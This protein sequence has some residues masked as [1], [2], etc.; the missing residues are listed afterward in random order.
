VAVSV[1]WTPMLKVAEQAPPAPQLM[2][3]GLLATVPFPEVVT[4]RVKV[5]NANVAVTFFAASIVTMQLPAPEQA[6]DHPVKVELVAGAAVKV[7]CV[8]ES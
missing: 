3:A 7:T 8:P 5:L 4:E 1:T 2:P 6:P